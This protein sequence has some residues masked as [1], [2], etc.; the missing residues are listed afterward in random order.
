MLKYISHSDTDVST[1]LKVRHTIQVNV[2]DLNKYG[3]IEND[4]EGLLNGIRHD[5]KLYKRVNTGFVDSYIT[6][7]QEKDS[8]KVFYE[9]PTKKILLCEVVVEKGGES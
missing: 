3:E 9:T 6:Y 1:H 5:L 2:N 8:L 7:Q 4:F